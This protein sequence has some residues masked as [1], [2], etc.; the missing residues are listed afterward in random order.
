MARL[1]IVEDDQPLRELYA[2]W[3][4]QLGY[5]TIQ[6]DT[7]RAALQL[8]TQTAF[9]GALIDLWLPDLSGLAVL[10]GLRAVGVACIVVTGHGSCG[11]AVT[12]MRLGALDFLEKPLDW[13]GFV[14]AVIQLNGNQAIEA[15]A[16]GRAAPCA[17]SLER[18]AVPVVRLVD[19]PEDPRTLR[20]WGRTVGMSSG[21]IRN[22]CRTAGIP[23]RRS[24]L[25]ARVLRA[26]VRRVSS[27]ESPEQL[28]N[29]V[30][31]RTLVKVLA[32][33]G[34][35]GCSLPKDIDTFF[36]RQRFVDNALAVA[37][38]RIA[39]SE[40]PAE[41]LSLPPIA[42]PASCVQPSETGTGPAVSGKTED[43]V[44]TLPQSY[45]RASAV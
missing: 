40:R 5:E 37:E 7:A 27:V 17:H 26:V 4:T 9:D 11:A 16:S 22:W 38:V 2:Q 13:D 32:S 44:G 31:R 1:L 21:A 43:G 34:A 41:R 20:E 6:A 35:D 30:D 42:R 25:F 3:G 45:V 24:L 39:M 36:E 8:S 10:E 33:S 15:T 28:L 14:R 29:I 19:A 23:A 12:A 18:W